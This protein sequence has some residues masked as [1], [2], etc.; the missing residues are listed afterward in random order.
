[1]EVMVPWEA[2]IDWIASHYLKTTKKDRRPPYSLATMLRIHRL[3]QWYSPS[4][5]KCRALAEPLE[6]K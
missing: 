6:G 4:A 3:Q 5:G 1:M 2:L